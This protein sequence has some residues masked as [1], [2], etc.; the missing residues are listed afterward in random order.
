MAASVVVAD[1]VEQCAA[2][3]DLH[4]ALDAGVMRTSDVRG[5]LADVVSGRTVGRQSDDE[6]IIFDSTGTA[7]Q[8]VAVAALVY[9]RALA[10]G[11]GFAVDLAGP[12]VPVGALALGIA[13]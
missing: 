12:S 8:D 13:P 2:I 3:G 5:E 6:V 10:A 9:E 1:I 4:H 7:L 11:A